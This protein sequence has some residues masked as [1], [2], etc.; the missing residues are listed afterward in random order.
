MRRIWVSTAIVAWP[1]AMESTTL[2]VFR[3]TPGSVTSSSRVRGTSPPKSVISFS[4]S[5]MTFFA[6]L[7]KSPMVL[8]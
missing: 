5:A 3:P 6:L 7:R 8:M 4:L 1:K 2:A